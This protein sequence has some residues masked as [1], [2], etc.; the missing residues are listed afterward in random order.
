MKYWLAKSEPDVYSWDTL[1]RDK[2]GTWDGVR[3]FSARNN[4]R[5]MSRGD[6][7]LFY[8]SNIGKEVVGVAKVTR[9][10]YPD[11]TA[12][13]GDWSVVDVAPVK[14]LNKPVTLAQIKADPKFQ[15][16][17]LVSRS[18]LS[19][20]PVSEEHFLRVLSLGETKL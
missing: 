20:M 11:Q 12:T 8:H 9:E 7:V 14:A 16:M 18:R 13:T 4:L 15:D 19:V 10:H 5:A 17:L 2:K 6:L 1:V 3:N